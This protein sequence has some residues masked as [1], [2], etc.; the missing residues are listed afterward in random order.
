MASV[1]NRLTNAFYETQYESFSNESTE[2]FSRKIKSYNHNKRNRTSLLNDYERIM[3]YK[4]GDLLF[5][6]YNAKTKN[7]L[8]YYDAFP[9]ILLTHSPKSF[10][11]RNKEKVSMFSGINFHHIYPTQRAALLYTMLAASG[12]DVIDPTSYNIS[13]RIINSMKGTQ[14]FD[15]C[16]RNYLVDY[17]ISDFIKVEPYEYESAVYLPTADYRIVDKP[18]NMRIA[19]SKTKN[20]KK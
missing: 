2:W 3:S 14:N 12:S 9:L 13:R 20:R 17:R 7:K 18:V 10:K 15:K 16:F 5:F 8:P 4:V 6:A 19:F 11:K 1:L